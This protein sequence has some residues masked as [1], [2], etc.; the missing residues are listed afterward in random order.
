MSVV[1]GWEGDLADLLNGGYEPDAAC[2]M[3]KQMHPRAGIDI[4]K[5]LKAQTALRKDKRVGKGV[6]LDKP[7]VPPKT[8]PS[9]T[10]EPVTLEGGDRAILGDL[11]FPLV[12]WPFLARV[13]AAARKEGI[14][15]ATL[16]GDIMDMGDYS[17]YA[18][19]IPDPDTAIELDAAERGI[20]LLLATFED[21]QVVMGNHD[22]R[23]LKWLQG[24]L[25][26]DKATDMLLSFMGGSRGGKVKLSLLDHHYLETET[27]G[28]I[29][30]HGAQYSQMPGKVA[31]DM[32]LD[33]QRHAMTHHEHHFGMT[34]DRTGRYIAI[35]NGMCA[36]VRMMTYVMRQKKA[37]KRRMVQGATLLKGGYPHLLGGPPGMTDWKRYA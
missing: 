24:K 5:V 17:S 30:A 6:A 32:A 10:L 14:R 28:W 25:T 16:A 22:D 34:T 19:V 23:I 18:K 37:G 3:L 26:P 15:S 8:V 29:I 7:L 1:Y 13:C 27:G 12:D 9:V 2:L 31:G 36:D 35:S 33:E 4:H 21:V 20:D 11:H